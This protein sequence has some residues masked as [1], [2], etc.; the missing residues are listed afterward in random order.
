MEEFFDYI[1][2]L[3]LAILLALTG[4][5]V[6]F[7]FHNPFLAYLLL[8]VIG[9]ATAIGAGVFLRG[10]FRKKRL[11]EYY[12]LSLTITQT[13]KD[14]LAAYRKLKRP[15]QKNLRVF[16][17]KIKKLH[18]AA[19]KHIWRIH[20]IE[21]TLKQLERQHQ[22]SSVPDN[23]PPPAQHS[24]QRLLGSHHRYYD[25]IRTIEASKTRYLQEIQEVVQFFQSFQTQVVALRYSQ[26]Q[27]G[28]HQE[29]SETLHELLL[30]MKAL[31]EVMQFDKLGKS[32]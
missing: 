19:R 10:V 23:V 8:G 29:M 17:P 12:S 31:D 20:D 4:A 21:Q 11:R 25:N 28:M 24:Q 30:E 5:L 27:T 13:Y 1:L 14:I 32:T 18:K 2:W 9:G 7:L 22:R 3:L 6:Y 15:A 16:L 26:N